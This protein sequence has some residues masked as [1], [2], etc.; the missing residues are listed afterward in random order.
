MLQQNADGSFSQNRVQNIRNPENVEE[1]TFNIANQSADTQ[2]RLDQAASRMGGLQNLFEQTG[3]NI[4]QA[5]EFAPPSVP[6]ANQLGGSALDPGIGLTGLLDVLG[7][8]GGFGPADDARADIPFEAQPFDASGPTGDQGFAS[9]SAPI[10]APG[11][12]QGNIMALLTQLLGGGGGGGGQS[13][14][15]G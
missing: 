12:G 11:G 13:A 15:F 6:S 4:Q 1:F 3:G 7:I 8:G 5:L 2:Q 10:V 9:A 14:G